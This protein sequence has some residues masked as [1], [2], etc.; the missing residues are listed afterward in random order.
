MILDIEVP[1]NHE[2]ERKLLG[3]L[4]LMD[5]NERD[6][7]IKE[8]SAVWFL[9]KWHQRFFNVLY[10]NRRRDFGAEIFQA[11]MEHDGPLGGRTAWWISQLF[12]D[13]DGEPS[14]FPMSWREYAAI[15][16]R[17]YKMRVEILIAVQ[18]IEDKTN[19]WRIE[20]SR[21]CN[22]PKR[23]E[24]VRDETPRSKTPVILDGVEIPG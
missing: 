8:I 23:N 13:R 4:L 21:I 20:A 14:A 9:D 22:A 17:C 18:I 1:Q 12:L 7:A 16:A 19:E 24:E 3:A 10:S 15:I 2:A 6:E 5:P 11:M